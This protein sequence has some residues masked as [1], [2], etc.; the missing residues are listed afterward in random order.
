[1]A[2][3]TTEHQPTPVFPSPN[4]PNLFYAFEESSFLPLQL[5]ILDSYHVMSNF[6][7]CSITLLIFLS[8]VEKIALECILNIKLPRISLSMTNFF[9]CDIDFPFFQ[10]KN[11]TRNCIEHNYIPVFPQ[12][13]QQRPCYANKGLVFFP[14]QSIN[15][16]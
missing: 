3:M 5:F 10:W 16:D 15:P 9:Y 8:S 4:L 1:M 7:L 12:P 14:L 2:K 13:K 6:L 11:N